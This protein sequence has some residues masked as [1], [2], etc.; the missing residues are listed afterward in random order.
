MCVSRRCHARCESDGAEVRQASGWASALRVRSPPPQESH[1]PSSSGKSRNTRLRF[2][3]N[4]P[5][6]PIAWAKAISAGP[7]NMANH[8]PIEAQRAGH[9]VGD[10]ALAI[11]R[12][13]R[14][15]AMVFWVSL[16]WPAASLWARLCERMDLWSGIAVIRILCPG[17][18]I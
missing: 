10:R 7:W 18:D 11:E 5:S 1:S 17:R 15:P 6:V 2:R 4:G 3:A 8:N 16:T 12:L 14:W 13:G 9:S